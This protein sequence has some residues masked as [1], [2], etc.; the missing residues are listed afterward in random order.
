MVIVRSDG[1]DNLNCLFSG[2]KRILFMPPNHREF[3]ER[4]SMGWIDNFAHEELP[5]AEQG[6]RLTYGLYAGGV[7]LDEPSVDVRAVDLMRYPGTP[8]Q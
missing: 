8:C 1:M 3:I 2:R 7:G 5:L 4:P 6:G